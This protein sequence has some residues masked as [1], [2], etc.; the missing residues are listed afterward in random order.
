MRHILWYEGKV[1][2]KVVNQSEIELV[3]DKELLPLLMDCFIMES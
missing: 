1:L 2:R 3:M